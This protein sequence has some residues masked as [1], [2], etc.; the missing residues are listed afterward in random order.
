MRTN[1]IT[2]PV[3][4]KLYMQRDVADETSRGR[5][6][7]SG[8]IRTDPTNSLHAYSIQTT[9]F[10]EES[11]S[12]V[13][14]NILFVDS[15]L[16]RCHWYYKE[17]PLRNCNHNSTSTNNNDDDDNIQSVRQIVFLFGSG[18]DNCDVFFEKMKNEICAAE[19]NTSS[20]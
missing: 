19:N 7:F 2:A 3:D 15:S 14:D 8:S 18:R 16:E 10:N 1:G 20:S 9:A 6:L 13:V 4:G 12:M 17:M 5:C 11:V